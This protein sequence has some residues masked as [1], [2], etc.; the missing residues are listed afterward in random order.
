MVQA[1]KAESVLLKEEGIMSS[2]ISV[3]DKK[4]MM[5]D[6]QIFKLIHIYILLKSLYL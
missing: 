3:M 4:I 6:V 2:D 5:P 1:I